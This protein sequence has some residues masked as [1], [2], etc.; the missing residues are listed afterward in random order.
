MYIGLYASPI[1][2]DITNYRGIYRLN[3]LIDYSIL[4]KP[5]LSSACDWYFSV[6]FEGNYLKYNDVLE[7]KV[8]DLYAQLTRAG[9]RGDVIL[10][11]DQLIEYTPPGYS[12]WGYDICSDTMHYSPLGDGALKTYNKKDV[13]FSDISF[14]DYIQYQKNINNRG[15]FD[16]YT[17]ACG[18][19]QYCNLMDKKYPNSLE[20]V[21]NWRPFAIMGLS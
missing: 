16:S 8:L 21:G 2:S 5:T 6:S 11:S 10:F 3:D 7:S 12:F 18:F 15:L 1:N 14:D 13:F 20:S 4:D 19:A 9:W 17:I